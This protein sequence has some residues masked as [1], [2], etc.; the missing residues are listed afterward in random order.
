MKKAFRNILAASAITIFGLASCSDDDNVITIPGGTET[1]DLEFYGL[2]ETNSLVRI[3][4]QN[5]SSALGTTPIT[6]LTAGETIRA[7]DF[8]PATGQLYGLSSANRIYIINHVSGAATVVGTTA[9]TPGVNGDLVGFDFNPTVDRIRL[10]TSEGQNLRIHPETGAVAFTD[11]ELNPGTPAVGSA[12]YTNSVSGASSTTLFVIDFGSSKLFKQDPPNDGT[13]V[14]VGNLGTT[15]TAGEGGFD[16]SGD[17]ALASFANGTGSDLYWINLADG[18]ASDLGALPS[19]IVGLAIPTAP[20]AYAVDMSNNLQIFNPMEPGTPV[21]KP[22][23]NLASGENIVGI[24]MRPA[25][26]QLFALGSEGQLYRIDLGSAAATPIGS[27][28]ALEGTDFGFDFNPTVDRIRVVSNTG[29]NLRLNPN[30]GALAATDGNLNP[31][32]PSI[33]A[34]AYTN[35]YPG[36]TST[37]LF[38]IDDTTDTLFTQNPPNDGVLVSVG[39]LG[40]DVTGVSGFDIGGTSNMAHAILTVGDAAKVYS[41]NLSTG[42]ATEVAAYPNQVRGFTL[43]LGF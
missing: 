1:P 11:G 13:L 12:A 28:V 20:V 4:A 24:D 5:P 14:E 36:T 6:G 3:N 26:G 41:I 39:A 17:H 34:A 37:M 43:G 9:L 42:A 2:T 32:T 23:T 10:V 22:V 15:V 29:Q 21:S 27:P 8:R 33:S 7:I 38:D 19:S 40:I 35:N 30:D 16:I 25:T 18:S 31:G